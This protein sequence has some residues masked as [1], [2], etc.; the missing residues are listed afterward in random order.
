MPSADLKHVPILLI[1]V[2]DFTSKYQGVE[3]KRALLRHLQEILTASARFFMPYGDVWSKWQRLPTGDGY[4]FL[5]GGMPP[6][7]ALE[8]TLRLGEDLAAFNDGHP[9]LT[10]RLRTVLALG[11][12]ERVGDQMLSEAFAVAERFISYRPFK[13]LCA[14]RSEPWALAAT[15]LYHHELL[16]DLARECNFERLPGL[17]WT[18]VEAVDKHGHKHPGYVLGEGWEVPADEPEAA[19][20]P[21]L[22]ALSAAEARYL[23]LLRGECNRLP[24]ADDARDV[25]TEKVERPQLANVYVDL[26]TTS[27]P[28]AERILDRLNVPE[29]KR[30]KLLDK[31]TRNATVRSLNTGRNEDVSPDGLLEELNETHPLRPW[32]PDKETLTNARSPLTALE[33]LSQEPY[34]VLLGDPGSGKSTLVNHL[35]V[36]LACRLLGAGADPLETPSGALAEP[37]FPVRIVLRRWS[38]GLRADAVEEGKEHELLY[39]ALDDLAGEV[40]RERWLERFDDPGTLLLLDGL[41][42][43]PAGREEEAELDRRRAI[44]TAVEAFRAAHPDC[45]VLVTCRVKPYREGPCQIAACPT[46]E[47]AALDDERIRRFCE[48]WYGELARVGRLSGSEAGERRERLREALADRPVLREM[49]GTPLLLTMLARVNARARLPE[50]RAELYGECVEQLLWEWERQ[51]RGGVS[52]LVDLLAEPAKARAGSTLKRADFERVLWRLTW[53]AHGKSGKEGIVDLPFDDL[54]QGLAEIH[55]RRDEGWAWANRVIELMRERGGL[56]VEADPG[57]FTFPHRSFQEYLACRWLLEQGNANTTAARLATGDAWGEVILLSC[58]YLASEGRFGDL[59][60]IVAALVAG[61]EPEAP[62]E[63]RRVLLAGR[64]WLEFGPHR[65]QERQ[66]EELKAKVPRLLTALMQHS[67]LQPKQRLEAGLLVADLGEL[68]DDLDAWVEIPADT[69]DYP[70]KIGKYPVTNAQYRRFVDVG[71]YDREKGWFSEEAQREIL[72]W[73]KKYGAKK[74]PVGPRYSA[75]SRLNRAT[76][77]VVGVSRYEAAAYAEWLAEQ[78]RQAGEIDSEETARLATEAEWARVAGGV[79]GRDY[80][81]KGDFDQ[82]LANTAESGL[83]QPTPVHMYSDGAT[84]ERVFDLTGNVWEWTAEEVSE[85]VFRLT[86][87]SY[88]NDKASVGASARLRDVRCF[89]RGYVGFRLVVVPISRA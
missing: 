4:Y 6:Q 40:P 80:S 21:A 60:A 27:P 50:S 41:D 46:F 75:R 1:D 47:L 42:E 57:V 58:G 54:R 72:D 68:P 26:E 11:D 59:Q 28:G 77:P 33:A 85:G 29:S 76:Q 31:L 86:G 73:E 64:A 38:A 20:A 69:L 55:P 2:V 83:N 89:R 18:K 16:E 81:W 8:Y 66:G 67:D 53:E 13:E 56:L 79:E 15:A 84:P 82:R 39:Q 37:W 88:W 49:A 14:R 62:E 36:T 61:G 63:W 35:A 65:A 71:G 44:V 17:E 32:A 24:L 7:V 43:V 78:L 9:D 48:R 45:L 10:I 12:V 87:G 25:S 70:F 23:R 5:F 52:S 74:W 30:A 19:P 3:S 51:K 22:G 34:M